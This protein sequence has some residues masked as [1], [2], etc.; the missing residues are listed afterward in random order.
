MVTL[1]VLA[2]CLVAL[3]P[4]GSGR[5]VAMSL[6]ISAGAGVVLFARLL[7]RPGL[8]RGASATPS[9]EPRAVTERAEEP[10]VASPGVT[11]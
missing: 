11:D 6:I 1:A 5:G 3:G 2:V 4:L 9:A 7:R 8:V 10:V